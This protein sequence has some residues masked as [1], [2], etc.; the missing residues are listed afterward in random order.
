[1]KAKMIFKKIGISCKQAKIKHNSLNFFLTQRLDLMMNKPDLS[2]TDII[3]MVSVMKETLI[4]P[5]AGQ[6]LPRL[7]RSLPGT[8]R[9]RCATSYTSPTC[10]VGGD[11]VPKRPGFAN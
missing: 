7:R 2:A 11:T 3:P 5:N 6:R 8:R 4:L 9:P 1:M 10:G